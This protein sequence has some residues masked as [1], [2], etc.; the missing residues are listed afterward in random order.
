M[1]SE[2]FVIGHRAAYLLT[3]LSTY[4][5][6]SRHFYSVPT[7]HSAVNEVPDRTRHPHLDCMHNFINIVK[8]PA[9]NDRAQIIR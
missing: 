8:R 4:S 1:A 3:I 7:F 5:L 2:A 9:G 6:D